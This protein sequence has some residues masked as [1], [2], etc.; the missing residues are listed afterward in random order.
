MGLRGMAASTGAPCRDAGDGAGGAGLRGY[1]VLQGAETGVQA[2]HGWQRSILSVC[3]HATSQ[4]HGAQSRAC[5]AGFTGIILQRIS[6]SFWTNKSF[7]HHN[8][9]FVCFWDQSQQANPHYYN[10]ELMLS[11]VKG[12]CSILV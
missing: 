9:A 10:T 1:R 11:D 3:G 6:C 7:I 5:Q 2:G 4:L 8:F 12:H